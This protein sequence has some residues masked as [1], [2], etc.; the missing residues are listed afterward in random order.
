[1]QTQAARLLA[2]ADAAHRYAKRH[3]RP[4]PMWGNGSLMAR[5]MADPPTIPPNFSCP[6]SL[7]AFHAIITALTNFRHYARSMAL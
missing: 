6:T 2:E 3:G 5:A 1:M 4:H 7:A